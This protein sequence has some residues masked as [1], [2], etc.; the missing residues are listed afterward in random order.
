[1]EVRPRLTS[2]TRTGKYLC[3][4]MDNDLLPSGYTGQSIALKRNVFKTASGKI[5]RN[6]FRKREAETPDLFLKN[7]I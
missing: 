7:V 5:Y 2:N 1:M 6:I 3:F 4:K